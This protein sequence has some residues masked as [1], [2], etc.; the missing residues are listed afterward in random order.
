MKK[1]VSILLI[2][3]FIISSTACEKK[4]TKQT[5]ALKFKEEYESIN[6]QINEKNNKRYRSV[7]ILE[8]NPFVYKTTDDIVK[9]MKNGESFIVYF[10][11]K[12]CPWCRSI[13]EQLVKTV[14]ETKIGKVYYVDIKEIRDVKEIDEEGNIKTTKEG[15]KAYLELIELLKDVLKEYTLTKDEEEISTGEKRIYAPNVVAVSKGKPIQ[16]E[17]GISDELTDPYMEL[18]EEIEKYAYNK[19]KCLIKCLEEES[20]TCEKNSC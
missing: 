10:G 14:N 1:I 5:D 15:D 16:L 13:I 7:S 19:F 8:N 6:N 3:F 17:T 18:T 20:T 9:R 12:D 2:L 4:E 11:F